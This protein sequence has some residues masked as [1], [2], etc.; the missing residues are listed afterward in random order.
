[1]ISWLWIHFDN[2]FAMSFEILV[3]FDQLFTIHFEVWGSIFWGLGLFWHAI[4]D[5]FGGRG[6]TMFTI[7]FEVWGSIFWGRG[8]FWHAIHD[9]FGGRGPFWHAIYDIFWGSG[10]DIVRSRSILTRYLRWFWRSRCIFT[11]FLLYV[12]RFWGRFWEGF[13]RGLRGP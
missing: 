3:H 9:G 2:L 1:M 4:H 5:S 6:G 8:S 10:V 13:C 11:R 12:L 7:H